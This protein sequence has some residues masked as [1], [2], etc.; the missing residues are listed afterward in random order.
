VQSLDALD[1]KIRGWGDAFREVDQRLAFAQLDQE[2]DR[3]V[4][5]YVAWFLAQVQRHPPAAQRR[6][7]GVAMLG[8]TPLPRRAQRAES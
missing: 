8:D 5:D 6:M 3:L 7:W 1:C 4:Q 2:I